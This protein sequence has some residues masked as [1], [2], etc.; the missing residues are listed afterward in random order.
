[1]GAHQESHVHHRPRA[2]RRPPA[3]TREALALRCPPAG[4][5]PRLRGKNQA[6]RSCLPLLR[7]HPR[8]RKSS[9]VRLGCRRREGCPTQPP[10]SRREAGPRTSSEVM[11]RAAV[12][13]PLLSTPDSATTTDGQRGLNRRSR[14]SPPRTVKPPAVHKRKRRRFLAAHKINACWTRPRSNFKIAQKRRAVIPHH[15]SKTCTG[16]A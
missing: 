2:S 4:R 7:R 14:S 12:L 6:R 15:P 8:P 11:R 16:H 3:W 10:L 9:T 5:L 1:M 13:P